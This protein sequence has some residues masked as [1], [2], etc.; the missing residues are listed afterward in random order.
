MHGGLFDNEASV[1]SMTYWG[2]SVNGAKGT[3]D[4]LT[5][6][7]VSNGSNHFGN[8]GSLAFASDGS[9]YL[10]INGFVPNMSVRTVDL[11]YG[12]IVLNLTGMVSEGW[13]FTFVDLF[14]TSY[15]F[16]TLASLSIGDQR[17]YDVG[18]DWAFTYVSGTWEGAPVPEPATLAILAL[19]LAGL[20]LARRRRK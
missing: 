20:G 6:A 5:L 19:G 7:G 10:T 18:S 2:G 11:D 16:G 14:D 1:K 8:V 3:I 15:V 13:S 12:N 9:G 4:A 17:F